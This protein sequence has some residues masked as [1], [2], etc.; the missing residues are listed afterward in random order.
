MP[1][2]KPAPDYK[3]EFVLHPEHDSAYQHFQNTAANPFEPHGP[4]VTQRNAWWLADAA[5]LAYW[6]ESEAVR[7]FKTAGLTSELV[8]AEGGLQVYVSVADEFVI[9]AFRGSQPD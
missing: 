9:V 1:Q 8:T 2:T 4:G 3:L 5:L 6:G 7:R